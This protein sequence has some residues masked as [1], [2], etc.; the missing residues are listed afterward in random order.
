MK[1]DANGTR[2]WGTYYG[3]SSVETSHSICIS[4]EGFIYVCGDTFSST[5][6]ASAGAH[7][8]TYG[9]GID[10][11]YLAKF[12]SNGQLKWATYYGGTL[13]DI[14][15]DVTV[16]L[17][18]NVLMCGH[19]ESANAIATIGSY[20]NFQAGQFDIFIA[21]FDSTG[22]RLWGT[23]F[24]D[25]NVEEAYGI[26]CDNSNNI[27]VSGFT[28]S[29]NNIATVGCQQFV[30]GGGLQDGVIAKFNSGGNAVLWAT[31]YGGTGDDVATGIVF[32]NAGT[33]IIVGNTTSTNN[34]STVGAYQQFPGSP[35]D[36]FV[37]KCNLNGIRQWGTYFGG[38][39][40]DYADAVV[41][42]A[43]A[44]IIVCGS[45]ISTDVMSSANAY[46]ATNTAPNDYD[47]YFEKFDGNGSRKL[48][49]F[50]G[51]S[52]SDYAHGISL[53]SS[54]QIYIVGET[55]S[56][57]S[58]A[59]PG[60][61]LPTYS[62]SSDGFLGKFC[63]A[64]EP[65]ISPAG[66]TL[67]CLGQSLAIST[68]SGFYS[69]AWN[70]SEITPGFILPPTTP[71]GTYYFTVTV[72]DSFGCAGISDTSIIVVD[73]C[74]GFIEMQDDDEIS[75]FPVPS[76]DNLTVV[77]SDNLNGERT[78]NLF[79][80]NGK[81]V[82]TCI[83]SQNSCNLDLKKLALGIYLL[84]VNDGKELFERKIIKE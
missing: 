19:S 40:T 58:I 73:N 71:V 51:G 15:V 24:G 14:A 37:L 78:V 21:K 55:Y 35:E 39:N 28:A 18:A 10:D 47:A 30:Y 41:L 22:T 2:I 80:A 26:T 25:T 43:N 9:G 46:Q 44:N 12:D 33:L 77:F 42:D 63:L 5:G 67:I 36:I 79:S 57:D 66:S 20:Q 3:G 54:G 64:P 62:S 72:A 81:L 31:Y 4:A 23:Y 52:S 82:M 7:Q 13:H 34:I 48:G 75:V 53:N 56:P 50:Y 16:D 27:Y 65:I 69:Y 6:I 17:N 60:S 8:T 11:A 32:D 84:Q 70:N 45:T 74:I 29:Q 68:D 49:T 76:N 59:T 1:F 38:N 83:T 61:F